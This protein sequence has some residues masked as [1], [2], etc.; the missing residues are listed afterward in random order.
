MKN[1]K[2]DQVSSSNSRPGFSTK[3]NIATRTHSRLFTQ[4]ERDQIDPNST[5]QIGGANW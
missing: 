4:P 2:L 1:E 5:R 3:L